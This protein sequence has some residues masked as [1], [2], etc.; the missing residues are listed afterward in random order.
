VTKVVSVGLGAIGI[1]IANALLNTSNVELIAAVD[2]SDALAGRSLADAVPNAPAN[3]T[4]S[5]GLSQILSGEKKGVVVQATASRLEDIAPQLETII[6]FGW[7]VISTSEELT[8]ARATNAGLAL[9]LDELASK[10]GVTVLGAG[11]N[12][13]FLMDVLPLLLTGLCLR[14]DSISV[15]R[16][17]DTNHRRPQLQKKVGVGM[18]KGDFKAAAAA[19]RLGHVGLRQSAHLIA[20]TLGWTNLRYTETLVP[21]I[22]SEATT[23][24]IAA[25]AAGDAIGQRQLATVHADDQERV[26]LELEMYSGADAEDRIEINGEP[27]IHQVLTGGVNGDIATAAVISNLVG[28]VKNARPGLATMADL[29]PLACAPAGRG[30]GASCR[31]S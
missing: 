19:G 14:V 12:P 26:R 6:G 10:N 16:I 21:V 31:D 28:A 25:V 1:A 9:H 5:S 4:I 30:G 17:V 8:N 15:R 27:S 20:E 11:V 3:I 22:A 24:P 7:N 23:T 18:T 29:L 2:A 13:G